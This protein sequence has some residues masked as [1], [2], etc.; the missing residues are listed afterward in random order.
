MYRSP[1][2]D[3]LLNIYSVH[4][5]HTYLVTKCYNIHFFHQYHYRILHGDKDQSFNRKRQSATKNVDIPPL[6]EYQN[7]PEEEDQSPNLL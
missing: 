4:S 1:T 3:R 5:T 7:D 2:P 6:Q